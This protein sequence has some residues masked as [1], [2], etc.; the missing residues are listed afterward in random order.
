MKIA[1]FS[2]IHWGKNKD[3]LY[4]LNQTTDYID[5]FIRRCMEMEIDQVFFLGDWFENR[6]SLSV[7]TF[8]ES[9]QCLKKIADIYPV[10]MV[11]G[12]HDMVMKNSMEVTSV[13]VFEEIPGVKVVDDPEIMKFGDRNF[14]MYPYGFDLKPY[15]STGEI[16]AAFGHFEF[17]GAAL[18]GHV[19]AGSP[20][21]IDHVSKIAPLTFSGHFHVRK[22]Y[23]TEHGTVITVGCPFMLDWGDCGNSKGIWTIDTTDMSYEFHENE[24][25]AIYHKIYWSMVQKGAQKINPEEIKGNFAKLI[26]DDDYVYHEVSSM[27]DEINTHNPLRPCVTDFL[28][29]QYDLSTSDTDTITKLNINSKFDYIEKYIEKSTDDRIT[30]LDRKQLIDTARNFYEKVN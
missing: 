26:I 23:P 21:S 3:A 20:F 27:V 14:L 10:T 6:F 13:K 19:H 1:M 16:D 15:I 22:E 9:Y 17:N 30:K 12:N 2:D 24:H 28:F 5:Y 25:S 4:R 11:V 18:V 8:V 29:S 7:S